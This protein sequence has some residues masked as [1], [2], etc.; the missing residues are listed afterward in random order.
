MSDKA[1]RQRVLF[2]IILFGVIIATMVYHV[3]KLGESLG[4]APSFL[5]VF[6]SASIIYLVF[7]LFDAVIIDW[8]ILMV[9]WPNLGVLPGTEGMAGYR[10]MRLWTVNLLKSIPI[11][12]ILGL[13]TAGVSL[14]VMWVGTLIA[15]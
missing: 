14:L 15:Q 2:A 6:A 11:S 7:S 9:L 3:Y 12:L 5:V 13:I 10:D 1:K 4:S 8:L